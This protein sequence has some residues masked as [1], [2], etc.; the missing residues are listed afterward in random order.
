L[1]LRLRPYQEDAADFLFENDTAMI[2]A[3]VGAGKTAITLTA[4]E[5]AA[6]L[7]GYARRWLILAPKRVCTDVWPIERPKW[8]SRLTMS[9]AVGTPKARAAALAADVNVVVMNYDNIQTLT[10]ADMD[11][12]DGVVFDELTRVKNPSGKRFKALEKLLKNV[13]YRW[14]LTGS[15][16]SN[17][18]EDVFGQ[19]K[20]VD[21]ALLG[22]S[23]GAFLQRYFVCI[24][25]DFGEWAPRKG[26]LE[27]IMATIK[28]ATFVL[29]P[30]VYADKLP[31]LH[32]VEL[33]CDMDDIK[34]YNVMKRDLMLEL[35]SSQVVAANAAAVTSKLQQ[36]ASGFV[37]HTTAT[38]S[39]R[40]GKF[41]VDKRAIW[42]SYHKF[43]R[44]AELLDENQRANTLVVYN[45]KEELAELR[46]R[47]PH[48]QTIDDPNA[49]E[50][51][52]AGEIELLLIHPKCLHPKTEVLTEYRGWVPIVDVLASERVFDGVEYVS[53]SGCVYSG[54]ETVVERFGIWMTPAHRLLVDGA[55]VEAKDVGT[56]SDTERKA[57]YVYAGDDA[58]LRALLAVQNNAH[59][60]G[61]ELAKAY[62]QRDSRLQGLPRPPDTRLSAESVGGYDTPL[63]QPQRQGVREL[64]RSGYRGV[65]AM[66]H[67]LQRFLFR[68]VAHLLSGHDL[69]AARRERRVRAEQLPVGIKAGATGQQTHDAAVDLRGPRNP[70]GGTVQGYG[71]EPGYSDNAAQRRVVGGRGGNRSASVNIQ[72]KPQTSDVYDLVDCG[73]RNRFVIRNAN[74]EVFVSHNSAGHGLNLQHGGSKIVFVSLPWSLELYEQT[75]G[76]LHRGGQTQPVWCYLLICNKTIDERIWSALNDKRAI[77]DIAL[78][79]LKA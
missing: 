35:G 52:N 6:V 72:E 33:T 66:A 46:R 42:I 34:P 67:A 8:A 51:W 38:A 54:H 49:I 10:E 63:P 79:E 73:P 40:P 64:R 29:E 7:D 2:L 31:P 48:A 53:H 74:G 21:Q 55:W 43:D 5:S 78:E 20:I 14:G 61:T 77:S 56:D 32:T 44:L 59:N 18:L 57:R 15:F 13:R 3:P 62:P 70:F 28:P 65:P 58:R 45:Y 37:Y 11:R 23:K 47:F 24:N 25:R 75:V 69:R 26:S 76:R 39:D 27:Q 16:T 4:L 68:H 30:G 9:L 50:R 36:M 12:F 19:C 22:R 60:V 17:G 71:L 1:T 41:N